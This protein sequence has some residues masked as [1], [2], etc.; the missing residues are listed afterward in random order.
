MSESTS[1]TLA[2]GLKTL[3]AGWDHPPSK[4]YLNGSSVALL[5][6]GYWVAT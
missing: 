2:Y 5:A 4:L 1:T 6:K 3:A